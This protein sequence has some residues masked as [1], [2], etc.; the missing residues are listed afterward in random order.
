VPNT[1]AWK[2]LVKEAF[3][4]LHKG[5]A[6]DLYTVDWH[7][8]AD[9]LL[10][11]H[12]GVIA[13]ESSPLKRGLRRASAVVYG[14]SRRLA[15]PRRL[16]FL[17]VLALTLL[18]FLQQMFGGG[19]SAETAVFLL[20]VAVLLLT[21]LLAL[22]LVD[23]LHFRDELLMARDLQAELVPQALPD[24]PPFALAG[25]SRVANTVGGD[26]YDFVRLGDGRLAVLFGDASG[27]G[28]AAGLVM[29]VVHTAFR[30]QLEVDPAPATVAA[31]LN[32]QLCR[33]GECRVA[34]P[35]NFFAG[36]VLLFAPD[37][38]FMAGHPP[39]LRLDVAGRVVERVGSGSYPMGIKSTTTWPAVVGTLGPGETLLLFSDGLPEARNAA[40]QEFGDARVEAALTRLASGPPAA[41]VA[42]LA[43]D[44]DAFLGRRPAEDDV[45]IA[46]IR[47]MAGVPG[48]DP[49]SS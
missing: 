15:P 33:I 22:E 3:G 18:G 41:L 19:S 6:A 1:A 45:S 11:E 2:A 48:H 27:H 13:A 31:T 9:E 12:E 20:L 25:T 8:V 30:T 23:K 4:S 26:L 37:G 40:G 16:V 29:A 32:R 28:M 21:F 39:L 10:A 42:G 47:R 34:G 43:S 38:C 46:A 36:V 24:A 14:L 17:A 35:R 44:L 49:A 7:R 5:D